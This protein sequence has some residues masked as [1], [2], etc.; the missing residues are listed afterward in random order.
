MKA[1][2][3]HRLVTELSLTL[4]DR[5]LQYGDGLF[6]TIILNNN[7][8][9]LLPLHVNRLKKGMQVLKM[10][11]P[12]YFSEKFFENQ[13]ELLAAANQLDSLVVNILVWRK[14][15][16]LYT[17]A[18]SE[19]NWLLKCRS[20][21]RKEKI[22]SRVG[23]CHTVTNN[24]QVYSPFKSDSLKY[25]LAA[26]EKQERSLD[27]LIILD[28]EGFISETVDKNIFWYDGK[29]Y[30]TPSI[31]TGCIAGVMREQ[32]MMNFAAKKTEVVEGNFEPEVLREAKL[33]LACN[34][35]GIYEIGEVVW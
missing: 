17:P 11:V 35:S 26:M 16:G 18:G 25:V 29:R 5:G 7:K 23:I 27:D 3:N 9:Q 33:M 6:E 20:Y 15:G 30:F 13:I 8:I 14:P 4:D 19:V 28:T 12:D 22:L 1:I 10:Q 24:Y 2:F 21:K 32:L 31:N 34:A